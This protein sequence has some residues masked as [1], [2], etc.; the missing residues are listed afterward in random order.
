MQFTVLLL[1]VNGLEILLLELVIFHE[2]TELETWYVP[3]TGSLNCR[4]F[5]HHVILG[6]R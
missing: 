6:L 2:H 5:M 1:P 3:V 4:L